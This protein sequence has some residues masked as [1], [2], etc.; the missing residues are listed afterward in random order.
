VNYKQIELTLTFGR[1]KEDLTLTAY[2][3]RRSKTTTAHKKS[4]LAA[5]RGTFLIV[6]F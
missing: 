3:P 5:T 4:P 6:A 1:R 2:K